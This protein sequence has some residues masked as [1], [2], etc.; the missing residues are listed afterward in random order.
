MADRLD[1][2]EHR[3]RARVEPPITRSIPT[4]DVDDR[5]LSPMVSIVMP[6]DPEEEAYAQLSRLA[7][8]EA[9]MMC[10]GLA[11]VPENLHK[12]ASLETVASAVLRRRAKGTRAITRTSAR[13]LLNGP[14][15]RWVG[16]LN[17]PHD[18]VAT[19]TITFHGGTSVLIGADAEAVF[20]LQRI[21]AALS[22]ADD[23]RPSEFATRATS[24]MQAIYLISDRVART[25]GLERVCRAPELQETVSVPPASSLRRLL[26]AVRFDSSELETVVGR[27]GVRRSDLRALG[28]E[29]G[30]LPQPEPTPFATEHLAGRPL[31]WTEHGGIVLAPHRLALA[32]VRGVLRL[33]R[34][35]NATDWLANAFHL[36]VYL[37]LERQLV[38]LGM[39]EIRPPGRALTQ[40]QHGDVSHCFFQCDEDKIVHVVLLTD[41]LGGS[42]AGGWQPDGVDEELQSAWPMVRDLFCGIDAEA[43]REVLTIVVLA[44]IGRPAMLGLRQEPPEGVRLLVLLAEELATIAAVEQTKPALTPLILWKYAQARE[45]A[46][47]RGRIVS[48]FSQ[49]NTYALWMSRGRTFPIGRGYLVLNVALGSGADFRAEALERYAWHSIPAPDAERV[50]EVGRWHGGYD[51]VFLPRGWRFEELR[52]AVKGPGGLTIW[53]LLIGEVTKDSYLI[54]KMTVFWLEEFLRELSA[55]LDERCIENRTFVIE[56]RC[57]ASEPP[58]LGYSVKQAGDRSVEVAVDPSLSERYDDTNRCERDFAAVLV[59]ATLR[60]AGVEHPDQRTANYLEVAAPLGMKRML[61]A[62]R[63]DSRP[64]FHGVD[65]PGRRLPHETDLW[66]WRSR[67]LEAHPEVPDSPAESAGWIRRVVGWLYRELCSQLDKLDHLALLRRLVL[68]NESLVRSRGLTELTLPSEL[69][70]NRDR[71]ET[72]SQLRDELPR[73]AS[74]STATR[75]LV[76]LVASREPPPCQ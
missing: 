4:G 54:I 52:L 44:G 75:F 74:A 33:A 48:P 40:L 11:L 34:E 71:P 36:G 56:L 73:V 2:A 25:A 29:L 47:R 55:E 5:S 28:I 65:V 24:L 37:E 39:S 26:D 62:V 19:Q 41:A 13:K 7:P 66:I 22:V 68:A 63:T 76:E 51:T 8:E 69:A 46:E 30:T 72:I 18:T 43:T 64:E 45:H 31:L 67:A 21:G 59:A 12:L 70:C 60:A 61:H 15:Q 27:S 9:A 50:V 49:L 42:L 14:V 10:G 32:L 23:D 16:P 17:D 58:S 20:I 1:V 53:L 3:E 57:D 35:F 6:A 38:G